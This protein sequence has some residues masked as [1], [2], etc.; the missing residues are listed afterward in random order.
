MRPFE[1]HLFINSLNIYC[2]PTC[3]GLKHNEQ[4]MVQRGKVTCLVTKQVSSS[5]EALCTEPQTP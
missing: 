4:D 5:A 3:S 2:V 1:A